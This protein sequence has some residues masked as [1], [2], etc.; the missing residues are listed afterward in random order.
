MAQW[1]IP[2]RFSWF[3]HCSVIRLRLFTRISRVQRWIR[4]G[5]ALCKLPVLPTSL[6]VFAGLP[7]GFEGCLERQPALVAIAKYI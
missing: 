6:L 1:S 3:V 7:L 5:F 2:R 4:Y